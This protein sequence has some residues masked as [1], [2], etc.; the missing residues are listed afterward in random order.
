MHV[1]QWWVSSSSG[2]QSAALKTII[3]LYISLRVNSNVVLMEVLMSVS[4]QWTQQLLPCQSHA[5]A[6]DVLL[7]LF[8]VTQCPLLLPWLHCSSRSGCSPFCLGLPEATALP[9]IIWERMKTH[10]SFLSFTLAQTETSFFFSSYIY[11]HPI[12]SPGRRAFNFNIDLHPLLTFQK[13]DYSN[14]PGRQE[15]TADEQD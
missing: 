1:C 10:Q 13:S 12:W 15:A 6:E 2:P 14:I 9:R 7:L 3:S 5:A 4:F 11:V 8:A